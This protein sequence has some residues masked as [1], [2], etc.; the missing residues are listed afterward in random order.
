MVRNITNQKARKETGA[1]AVMKSENKAQAFFLKLNKSFI[2][3][4]G[5]SKVH[6]NYMLNLFE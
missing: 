3:V 2:Y 6:N 1:R 4:K 5:K